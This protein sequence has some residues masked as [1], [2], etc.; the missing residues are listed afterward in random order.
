MFWEYSKKETKILLN[1]TL[2][3][4]AAGALFLGQSYKE[5]V[6]EERLVANSVGIYAQV[7]KNEVNT[8]VA[9]LDEKERELAQREQAL[10]QRERLDNEKQILLIVALVGGSLLGLILLNFYLDAKRRRFLA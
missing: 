1:A 9:Q 5:T 7:Q 3:T 2:L 8:L 4:F 6:Q 10:I